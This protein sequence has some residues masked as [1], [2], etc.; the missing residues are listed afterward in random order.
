[1]DD[2][3]W[4][5]M[6]GRDWPTKTALGDA[7]IPTRLT[8]RHQWDDDGKC[9]MCGFDGADW[10]HQQKTRIDADRLPMAECRLRYAQA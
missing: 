4:K 2:K 6:A 7:L 5:A 8:R 1:M 10:L 3:T 9:V